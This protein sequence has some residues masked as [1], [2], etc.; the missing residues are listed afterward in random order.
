MIS[1]QQVREHIEN[2]A[3]KKV[4][5]YMS[6]EMHKPLLAAAEAGK[7]QYIHPFPA[8]TA[9]HPYVVPIQS[10]LKELAFLGYLVTL[11]EEL[12]TILTITWPEEEGVV[13]VYR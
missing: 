9:R 11:Q 6:E 12:D 5:E 2:L 10:L 8:P 3:I 4:R 13:R 1:A 7:T